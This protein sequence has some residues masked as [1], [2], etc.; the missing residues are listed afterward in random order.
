MN[1]ELNIRKALMHRSMTPP[2]I[3]SSYIIENSNIPN[4]YWR[5]TLDLV[6]EFILK[7]CDL[8]EEV[9]YI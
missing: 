8:R 3:S 5:N 6:T 9:I 4:F 7:F 1:S 2:T